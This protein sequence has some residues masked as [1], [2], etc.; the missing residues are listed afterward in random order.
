MH[1]I[2]SI[3]ITGIT[4]VSNT[5]HLHHKQQTHAKY[6]THA[7]WDDTCI[8]YITPASHIYIKERL[9]THITCVSHTTHS[10]TKYIHHDDHMHH[11]H[12]GGLPNI[13]NWTTDSTEPCHT[14]IVQTLETHITSAS[15]TP[16]K[17]TKRTTCNIAWL[18]R[19][20]AH[21]SVQCVSSFMK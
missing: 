13:Y 19:G 14:Q 16:T 2:H 6:I 18:T 4:P 7:S 20:V 11:I 1:H 5:Y 3:Y 9:L 10:H 8:T 21:T 15:Q 12:H 17:H